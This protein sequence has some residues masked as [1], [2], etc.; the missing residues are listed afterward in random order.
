MHFSIIE[1]GI[2]TLN[3]QTVA[4]KNEEKLSSFVQFENGMVSY[5]G[6]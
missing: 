2:T 6:L 5:R 3:F 1:H 4:Q